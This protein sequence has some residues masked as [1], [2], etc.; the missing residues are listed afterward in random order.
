MTLLCGMDKH[1]VVAEVK[2]KCT[3]EAKAC[4]S[5]RSSIINM[6]LKQMDEARK[7]LRANIRTF[8]RK[9]YVQVKISVNDSNA[10]ICFHVSLI[11]QPVENRIRTEKR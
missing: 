7:L 4:I 3:G 10:Q 11:A 2:A 8:Q 9:E 6:M 5:K 1:A